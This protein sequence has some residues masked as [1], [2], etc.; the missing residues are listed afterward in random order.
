MMP[1][2]D[3]F[4]LLA[5]V[6]GSSATQ[7]SGRALIGARWEDSRI[8]G[9]DA[10]ADDYLIKP[11][12]ARELLARVGALLEL[13]S[14]RRR[15]DEVSRRRTEQFETLLNEAPLGVFLVDTDFRICE[16]NP[17]ARPVFGDIPD[18]IGRD[19][20]E[21]LHILW[22][23]AYAD[24]L[25]ERF[26]HT[27]STGEPYETRERGER[28]LDRGVDEYYEW[29]INRILLPEGRYGVVCYFRDIADHV[30]ARSR[31]EAADRRKDEFLAMLAHELRNPLAPIRNASELLARSA[32]KIRTRKYWHSATSGSAVDTPRG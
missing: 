31:L 30:L 22:P 5:A 28:R 25:V 21:I 14:M 23:K 9:F 10:G 4:A 2:L 26:R 20:N 18:L 15:A 3:G 17:T 24:E 13:D 1:R 19:L 11:F 12:S 29:R 16:M 6:R 32:S 27:L 7:H 8:E